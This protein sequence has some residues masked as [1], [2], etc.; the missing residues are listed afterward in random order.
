MQ[1]LVTLSSSEGETSALVD[2]VIKKALS[3]AKVE[4]E[5]GLIPKI[6][7]LAYEDNTSTITI[8]EKGE[9][10]TGKNRHF[11]VRHHVL[12]EMIHDGNLVIKFCPSE[13]MIAD[14]LT[15]CK[16]ISA[17]QFYQQIV[18]AMFN[19]DQIGF[20]KEIKVIKKRFNKAN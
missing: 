3:L 1:D 13:K 19:E 20:E 16:G 10:Y 6:N 8:A 9:G 15:K 11:R 4:L 2:G 7:I 5:L 18:R 17:P 12:R 14:F